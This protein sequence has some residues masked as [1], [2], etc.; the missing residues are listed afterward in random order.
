MEQLTCAGRN[1]SLDYVIEPW[2][3][4]DPEVIT[5]SFEQ[6]GKETGVLVNFGCHATTLTGR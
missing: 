6:E 4:I 5:L 1:L 3:S 2:G